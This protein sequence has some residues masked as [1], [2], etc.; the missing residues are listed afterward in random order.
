MLKT[1]L[2]KFRPLKKPSAF[3]GKKRELLFVAIDQTGNLTHTMNKSLGMEKPLRKTHNC[4]KN[5]QQQQ[6]VKR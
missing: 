5:P 6:V 2:H 3:V 1:H 4:H